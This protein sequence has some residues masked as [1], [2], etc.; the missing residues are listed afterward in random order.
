MPSAAT[1]DEYIMYIAVP[2]N[3]P[4]PVYTNFGFAG[5]I[6]PDLMKLSPRGQGKRARGQ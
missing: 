1:L 3:T 6:H 2:K 4:D 5:S